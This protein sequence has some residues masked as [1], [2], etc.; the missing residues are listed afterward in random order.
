MDTWVIRAVYET[1]Q[2]WLPTAHFPVRAT[3]HLESNLRLDAD[4]LDVLAEE[5]GGRCRRTLDG[6]E[7]NP[8]Y[9]RVHTARDLVL[10]FM[11]QPIQPHA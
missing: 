1:L 9:G 2:D 5:I 11:Q 8:L 6:C 3:D 7:S 4:D 10:F